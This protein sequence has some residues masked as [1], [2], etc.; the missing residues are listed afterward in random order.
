MRVPLA[1]AMEATVQFSEKEIFQMTV[2][3]EHFFACLRKQL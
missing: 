2:H 1:I 3:L